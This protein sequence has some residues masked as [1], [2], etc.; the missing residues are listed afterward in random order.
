MRTK[1]LLM[2]TML[3]AAGAASACLN[4]EV[5]QTIYLA[6]SGVVWSAIDRD[7]RSDEST[8][9]RRIQEEG[10]FVAAA[11]A[12]THPVAEAFRR[13]GAQSVTT[14]WLRRERPY[15]VMTEAR[16]ADV[17]QLAVALLREAG[18]HGDVTLVR[19]GC[20]TTLGVR[21]DVEPDPAVPADSVVFVLAENLERYRFVL[22]AGHFVAADGFEI[23]EDRTLAVPDMTKTSLDGV[24]TLSLA[25]TDETCAGR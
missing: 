12:E 9:T 15:A 4:K 10:D 20:Q 11:N 6:P 3:V 24:L 2:G 25:W 22:V 23:R 16:F 19:E 17:R 14:T 5:T 8:M 7:V 18:L 13:L 1:S 21:T